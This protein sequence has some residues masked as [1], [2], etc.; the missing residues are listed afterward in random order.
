[1]RN[2]ILFVGADRVW[3]RQPPV[4]L[5][6]MALQFLMLHCKYGDEL[7]NTDEEKQALQALQMVN[8]G[9]NAADLQAYAAEA[10]HR[11]FCSSSILVRFMK[12]ILFFLCFSALRLEPD[13]DELQASRATARAQLQAMQ[14]R[15]AAVTIP[16]FEA[17][18]VSPMKLSPSKA[19]DDEYCLP[20]AS[21]S[22]VLM[23]ASPAKPKPARGRKRSKGAA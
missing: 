22:E 8:E 6:L 23:D 14:T 5:Q 10:L 18:L 17:L 4:D 19:D 12:L 20:G 13:N 11:A 2:T 21:T 15:N 3:V 7:G 1:M 16:F 9:I